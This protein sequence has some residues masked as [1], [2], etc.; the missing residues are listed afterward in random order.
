MTAPAERIFRVRQ[1]GEF[2]TDDEWRSRL[3]ALWVRR[4]DATGC[5]LYTGSVSGTGYGNISYRGARAKAHRLA[6][7]LFVG[8]IPDGLCVCHTCD[9]RACVNPRHLWLGTNKQ[10]VDDREEK[11]RRH[12]VEGAK[13]PR[14]RLTED[15]VRNIRRLRKA[16]VAKS[17]LAA[18]FGLTIGYVKDISNGRTWRSL[19]AHPR[20]SEVQP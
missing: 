11:G 2:T 12:C 13:N 5:L 7:R 18:Q 10:N 14:A 6:Y 16:G 17:L 20:P 4:D 3:S 9:N 19:E 8:E 1:R 15:D